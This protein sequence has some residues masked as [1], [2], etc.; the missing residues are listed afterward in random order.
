MPKLTLGLGST[1]A[2]NGENLSASL[3]KDLLIFSQPA[4][5]RKKAGFDA[6]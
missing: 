1:N 2:T 3:G 6:T 5:L 4:A